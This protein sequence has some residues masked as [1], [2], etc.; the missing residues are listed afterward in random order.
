MEVTIEYSNFTSGF[1]FLTGGAI[2]TYFQDENVLIILRKCLIDNNLSKGA[3]AGLYL[4]HAKGNVTAIECIISNN[5]VYGSVF[6]SGSGAGVAI[7]GKINTIF[8]SIKN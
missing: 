7:W 2:G 6:E 4:E 5:R 3:G 1:A 8:H